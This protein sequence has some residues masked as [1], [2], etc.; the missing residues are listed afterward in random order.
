M[1]ISEQTAV[2]EV[3]LRAV[4]ADDLEVDQYGETECETIRRIGNVLLF[5][6]ESASSTTA[7]EVFVDDNAAELE[8]AQRFDN[9]KAM[10]SQSRAEWAES[11]RS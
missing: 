1:Q 8:F 4:L 9:M 10:E 5:A 7:A 3:L 6:G 2:A 11:H